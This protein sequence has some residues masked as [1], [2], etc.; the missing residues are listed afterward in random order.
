MT[1]VL[2]RPTRRQLLE[3]AGL[4]SVGLLATACQS[5]STR[6]AGSPPATGSSAGLRDVVITHIHA[7]GLEPRTGATLLATHEGLFQ[8]DSQPRRVGPVIDLMGFTVRA[9][10]TFLASGHPGLG[11]ALTDPVGLLTSTDRGHTWRSRSRA[12]RSDFHALAATQAA[13]LGY[14]GA[15]RVTTDLTSWATRSIP[16]PPRSLAASSD[17]VVLATTEEGLLSTR[18]DGR[19]WARISTPLLPLVVAW[20]GART[21]VAAST[22]G[23]LL[24]SRDAGKTWDTGARVGQVEAIAGTTTT[25]QQTETTYVLGTRVLRTHDL[26]ASSRRLL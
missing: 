8:L 13:V 14:D 7:I 9:D 17:G 11:S 3:A 1:R 10:G 2:A 22:T 6:S 21:I 19:S 18:N 15:L 25:R 16:S 26:G 23:T 24:L 12:G 4:G 5:D 20:A